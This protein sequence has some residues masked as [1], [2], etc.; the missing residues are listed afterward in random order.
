MNKRIKTGLAGMIAEILF[1]V[2]F[3][4]AGLL[5]VWICWGVSR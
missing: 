1:A 4:A 5:I 2:L 3:G